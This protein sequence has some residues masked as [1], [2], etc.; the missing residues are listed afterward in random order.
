MAGMQADG[1][2]AGSQ[3]TRLEVSS[4][5]INFKG[6][7]QVL[8]RPNFRVIPHEGYYY[9]MNGPGH[10]YRSRGSLTNFEIEPHFFTINRGTL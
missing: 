7:P 4:D 2:D 3:L 10:L 8:G 6:K 5:G 9:A 1:R